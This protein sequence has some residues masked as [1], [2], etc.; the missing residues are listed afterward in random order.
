VTVLEPVEIAWGSLR[1][2]GTASAMRP[3]FDAVFYF[4]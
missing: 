3:R 4:S 2:A 1:L